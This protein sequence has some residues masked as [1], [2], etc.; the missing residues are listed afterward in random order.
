MILPGQTPKLSMNL[1]TNRVAA[2]LAGNKY[3]Q[4]AQNIAAHDKATAKALRASL[5]QTAG[6][7]PEIRETYRPVE[8]V[9]GR[10]VGG[11]SGGISPEKM[12]RTTAKTRLGEQ[13]IIDTAVPEIATDDVVANDPR[14]SVAG[15]IDSATKPSF[16]QCVATPRVV[17]SSSSR[18]Q[19]QDRTESSKTGSP[20]TIDGPLNATSAKIRFQA[21]VTSPGQM[22]SRR[23]AELRDAAMVDLGRSLIKLP[24]TTLDTSSY[25]DLHSWV[26]GLA[27]G[28][29]PES[30]TTR[31]SS[32]PSSTGATDWRSASDVLVDLL[33]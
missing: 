22:S 23:A 1:P 14:Q 31:P 19:P 9:N 27:V 20:A 11:P 29:P 24:G 6:V 3:Q 2:N 7:Q 28:P 10:R 33:E 12:P 18:S 4:L 15:E 25:T 32:R 21:T 17:G 13:L 16:S 5:A 8:V 30:V 26:E